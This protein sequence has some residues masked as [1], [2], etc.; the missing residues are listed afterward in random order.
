MGNAT[1]EPAAPARS[2]RRAIA[3]V[4][5]LALAVSLVVAAPSALAAVPDDGV[6]PS[7]PRPPATVEVSGLLRVVPVEAPATEAV[8]AADGSL[9][10]TTP[11]DIPDVP[12]VTL[13]TDDG[14]R[15]VLDASAVRAFDDAASGTR[16]TATVSVPAPVASGVADQVVDRGLTL[17]AAATAE[18]VAA[19]AASQDAVLEVV[20]ATLST[21]VEAAPDGGADPSA[22]PAL[23]ALTPR[24]HTV[25]VL[26]LTQA[27]TAA[28]PTSDITAA[29]G[30]LNSFWTTQ[31]NGQISQIAVRTSVQVR[32]PTTAQVASICDPEATWTYGAGVFGRTEPSYWNGQT[33]SH[34]VV[35]V[36]ASLCGIGLGLGTYGLTVHDGGLM[37]STAEVGSTA[38]WDQPLF[39]EFGH[40]ISLPHSNARE[41]T[42]PTIDS[43]YDATFGVPSNPTCS[44]REYAD[45]YDVMGGGFAVIDGAT[46]DRVLSTLSNPA[47]LSVAQKSRIDALP[48][49]AT[50]P[51]LNVID[52]TTR[53]VTLSP[54]SAT[55]GVRGVRAVDPRTGEH[56]FIEYRSGT[57]GDAA[58]L[59]AQWQ[60]EMG[61]LEYGPGVRV[62]RFYDDGLA[63][64]YA[65]VIQHL[66]TGEA[67]V[68]A[69]WYGAGETFSSYNSAVNV[70]V[71][72]TSPTQAVVEVTLDDALPDFATR[73]TPT[74]TG[75]AHWGA[76]LTASGAGATA[77]APTASTVTYQWLRNGVA[78]AGATSSTYVVGT[79]DIG[80]TIVVR[81]TA[82]RSGTTPAQTQ[83]RGVAI[84]GPAVDRLSGATRYDTA[85]AV[86]RRA[87]PTTAP[88]VYLA[89]GANYPDALAAAPAAVAQGG[90]LL[91]VP[92]T[93]TVPAAV[94]TRIAQLAPSRVV[95]VG[96]TGAVS[97]AVVAQVRARVPGA[98]FVRRAGA[99]RY[100]TARAVIAGAF[101]GGAGT[102]YVTTGANYPDALSA[103]AAAGAQDG[104]VVLVPGT[105]SS[106]DAATRATLVSLA[107]TRIIVVGGTA[108]VSSGIASALNT[109]AP[110]T[111][112]FGASRFETSAAINEQAFPNA[113][114]ARHYWATGLDFPDA[115][116]AAAVAGA[117]G[118]PLFVVRT[119]CV[120][121]QVAAHVGRLGVPSVSLVGG[122]GVVGPQVAA[123]TKC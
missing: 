10:V 5:A 81:A 39:H 88:V 101:G 14:A 27:G 91:L 112:I 3:A 102:V 43:A 4:G 65:T 55:S 114:L 76:T 31:S 72:S 89:T 77:W 120:P 100:G 123:L 117:D 52:G 122:T 62:Q 98:S 50:M 99:D 28:P 86:S 93:G 71:V 75:T 115:L 19:E 17:D 13:F 97:T 48:T 41:C 108:V 1:H 116:S 94:L 23:R 74:I 82:R 8:R 42:A 44:D 47:A 105:A 36:P 103:G 61:T 64:G 78:I 16:V 56:V 38:E 40:N 69:Q 49:S 109:I 95:V 12:A 29:I 7:D 59:Y 113:P 87:Y 26:W 58:S 24:P 85:I 90:P 37:W 68:R 70:R 11:S 2:I 80:R 67:P 57:G 51:T 21:P 121:P 9:T 104:A 6:G 110:T 60:A 22:P 106:L 33:A 66:I 53:T 83:S 30:R 96:G 34:L 35:L 73:A 54:A 15:V 79:A 107:P 45:R 46:G 92:S 32:T 84:S 25:D 119:T 63:I 118:S 111:R 20:D 18:L